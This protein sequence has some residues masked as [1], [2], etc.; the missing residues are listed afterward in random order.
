[1]RWNRLAGTEGIN[2][3]IKLSAT[4]R[5]AGQRN[6]CGIRVF[7]WRRLLEPGWGPGGRRFKSC[8][9]DTPHRGSIRVVHET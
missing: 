6:P 2:G 5:L 1:M 8:L 7:P 4:A 9:P 3:G